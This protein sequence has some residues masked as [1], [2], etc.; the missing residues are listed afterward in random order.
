MYSPDALTSV[1]EK[2]FPTINLADA[3][4]LQSWLS[5]RKVLISYGKP[6]MN[7]HQIFTSMLFAVSALSAAFLLVAS[8]DVDRIAAE[9]VGVENGVFKL[10]G[11]M[12]LI[13]L[14]YGFMFLLI[15][16]KWQLINDQCNL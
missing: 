2:V 11:P 7:R 16:R 5:M 9:V 8:F 12:T 4:S 1:G 3:V 10:V 14:F 6:Y 15:A 13:F